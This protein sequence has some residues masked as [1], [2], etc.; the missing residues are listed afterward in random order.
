[1]KTKIIFTLLIFAISSINIYA[2]TSK[3]EPLDQ[4]FLNLIEGTWA[5][6]S[7]MMGVKVKEELKCKMDHN[8]QF[9]FVDL[10]VL[11]ED[12][13]HT[14]SGTGVYGSDADGNVTTWWFDDWG[15]GRVS[16]GKGKIDGMKLSLETQS[17]AYSM[18]RTLELTGGRLIMKWTSTF[19]DKDGKDDTMTGETVYTK[20][21]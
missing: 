6:E 13:M 8:R 4:S 16:T 20:I 5:G 15:V 1:M 10:R 14:Y 18:N 12:K 17:S 9:L 2:Q 19:K 3:P 7:E 11:T 21:K